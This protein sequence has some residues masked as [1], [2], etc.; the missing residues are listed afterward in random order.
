MNE[1]LDNF[2]G[3][4]LTE[5]LHEEVV[6]NE[7][8]EKIINISDINGIKQNWLHNFINAG[9]FQIFVDFLNNFQIQS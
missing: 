4:I 1:L 5:E 3:H 8:L 7:E 9:A 2:K 6:S